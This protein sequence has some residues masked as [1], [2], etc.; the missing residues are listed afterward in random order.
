M[1]YFVH[2]ELSNAV[3]VGKSTEENLNSR[4][5]SLQ[6]GNSR[7]LKLLGLMQG[8]TE[9]EAELHL[10][11]NHLRIRGEWFE[12]NEEI[13]DY[14][15]T[16]RI[17]YNIK[18]DIRLSFRVTP[19]MKDTLIEIAKE[20]EFGLSDYIRYELNKIIDNYNTTKS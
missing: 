4:L 9:K 13:A 18:Q 3:K 10:K 16:N 5:T 6:T 8:Y 17:E 2:D 19:K 7:E 15:K 1:I 11:F 12:Y 14:I 20:R